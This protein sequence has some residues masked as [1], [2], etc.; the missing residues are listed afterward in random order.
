MINKTT[1]SLFSEAEDQISKDLTQ[2]V[3]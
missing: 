3:F 2:S 1:K